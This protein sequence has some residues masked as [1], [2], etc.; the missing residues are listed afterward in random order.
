[1]TQTQVSKYLMALTEPFDPGA[2]GAQIPDMYSFPTETQ[3]VRCEFIIRND[4][5]GNLDFIITPSLFQ[6]LICGSPSGSPNVSIAQIGGVF[7]NDFST[8]TGSLSQNATSWI[9]S[10]VCKPEVVYSQMARHRIVGMGCRVRCLAAPLNQQGR[11]FMASFPSPRLSFPTRIAGNVNDNINTGASLATYKEI[12]TWLDLPDPDSAGYQT[13]ELLNVPEM[14]TTDVSD[15]S[16]MG[17]VQWVNKPTSTGNVAFRDSFNDVVLTNVLSIGETINTINSGVLSFTAG[18]IDGQYAGVQ[19]GVNFIN[20]QTTLFQEG[21]YVNNWSNGIPPIGACLIGASEDWF[22]EGTHLVSVVPIQTLAN[23]ISRNDVTITSG[24]AT[25]NYIDWSDPQL[26]A[27]GTVLTGSIAALFPYNTTVVGFDT[28][29]LLIFLN[30]APL[31][32]VVTQTIQFTG[33]VLFATHASTYTFSQNALVNTT[34]GNIEFEYNI[35]VACDINAQE[36]PV[37]DPDYYRIDGWETLAVRGAG[38]GALNNVSLAVEVIF[39]VEGCPQISGSVGTFINGGQKPPV[40][41]NLMDAAV[42]AAQQSPYFTRVA[43]E[44]RKR[45][46]N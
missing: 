41:P 44:G 24:S 42:T 45:K 6:T 22:P 25:I 17:P 19:A 29:N 21:S 10:G 36:N 9:S 33:S 35:E 43:A 11:L 2:Q 3:V 34:I 27:F 32:G 1:M 5:N 40:Q 31:A 18:I 20:I 28:V 38:L 30:A 39:H 15:L 4:A 46:I 14:V 26:P 8:V 7:C 16:I 23:Y 37:I 12:C 13:T